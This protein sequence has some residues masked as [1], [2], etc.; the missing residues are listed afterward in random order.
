MKI[1][2]VSPSL[3]SEKAISTISL[4]L[5]KEMRD[6][7]MPVDIIQY[8]AGSP[9]S[10]FRNL[11]K[12]CKYDII[13]FQHEYN[14]LGY[15][16]LPLFLVFLLFWLIDSKIIVSMHTIFP[17]K[18]NFKEK[19]L[20]SF[21]RKILYISQNWLIKRVS[22]M[23][24]VNEN[25]MKKTLIQDYGFDPRRITVV[26]QLLVEHPPLIDKLK[27]KKELGITGNMFLIIGNL[28]GDVGADIIIRQADK[29]GGTII[30]A[31][32]PRGV[33]V[34]SKTKTE[35]Y[36]ELNKEIVK[37]KHF[38]KFVRFDLK[39]IPNAL[40]WKYFSAA[41]LILQAYR[42]GIRSGVFS[43]AMAAEVPV[44][45]SDISFFREM[46]SRYGSLKIARTESDYPLLIKKALKPDEYRKMKDECRR[47]KKE[48][49]LSVILKKYRNLYESLEK[50]AI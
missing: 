36:I 3:E 40:W 32:N 9:C 1:V 7:E 37:K 48:N 27:A 17:K 8:T 19:K 49:S 13:H 41:D 43:D 5:V 26:P 10:F 25:F 12:I 14:L 44:I 22:D 6:R 21:L 31:T 23:V 28:T 2:M 34:R 15:Y 39:G 47:Y 24:L 33:N 35:E 38:E 50:N 30:F 42:G 29:I 4:N 18:E 16:S 11:K 46:S 20:K 45:A